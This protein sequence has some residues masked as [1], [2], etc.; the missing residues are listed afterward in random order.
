[1]TSRPIG[2]ALSSQLLPG[3]IAG[4]LGGMLLFAL[5]RGALRAGFVWLA[6]AVSAFMLGAA[7][8]PAASA[9]VGALDANVGRS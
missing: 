7:H 6:I 8:L 3:L 4:V 1:M 5:R 2:S 9:P